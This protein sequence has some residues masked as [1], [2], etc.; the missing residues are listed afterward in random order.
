MD[1]KPSLSRRLAVLLPNSLFDL[2]TSG[3]VGSVR[4]A[5]PQA[6][7]S[8]TAQE[9][10]TF[11]AAASMLARHQQEVGFLWETVRFVV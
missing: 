5:C 1:T 8:G 10:V 11:R 2:S 7:C 3:Q 4:G 9:L 6:G